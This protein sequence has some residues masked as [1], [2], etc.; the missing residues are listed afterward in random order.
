MVFLKAETDVN[1]DVRKFISTSGRW[2]LGVCRM[3]YGARVRLGI[4]GESFCVLD[5]CGGNDPEV[6]ENLLRL[7]M[8]ILLTVP[9][10]LDHQRVAAI[11]P[12]YKIKPI[13][14]DQQCWAT[15]E[16]LA[17]NAISDAKPK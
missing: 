14:L 5:Y 17:A 13:V 16:S 15:L 6:L 12:T 11:F 8:T 10:E 1:F 4:A 3:I 2:E 7:V 9:E